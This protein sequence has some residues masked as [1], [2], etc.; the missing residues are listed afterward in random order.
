MHSSVS[1][2][3]EES[4]PV[5]HHDHDVEDEN[6]D[7]LEDAHSYENKSFLNEITN[8]LQYH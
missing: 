8:H 5:V 4:A 2:V 7:E 6:E 3:K 1:S